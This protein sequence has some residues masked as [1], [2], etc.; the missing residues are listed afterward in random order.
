MKVYGYTRVNS[1]GGAFGKE[2]FTKL[3]LSESER[4]VVMYTDY[5]DAFDTLA[6]DQSFEKEGRKYV[7]EN[8]SPKE[9]QKEFMRKLKE[10]KNVDHDIFGLIQ[11]SDFHVEYEPFSQDL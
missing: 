1:G 4:N 10:S 11:C 8:G 5:S 3:F 9:T 6:A 2:S 7:D